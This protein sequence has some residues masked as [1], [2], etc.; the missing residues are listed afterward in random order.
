MGGYRER[1]F[2]SDQDAAIQIKRAVRDA[3]GS[4]TAAA[5]LLGVSFRT[6]SRYITKLGIRE[7]IRTI[8]NELGTSEPAKPVRAAKPSLSQPSANLDGLA[9]VLKSKR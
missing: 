1:A 3:N 6:L 9:S 7:E 5:R 4:V 8:R 2:K